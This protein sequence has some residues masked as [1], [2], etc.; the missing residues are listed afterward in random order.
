MT[1]RV[2]APWSAQPVP[3]SSTGGVITVGGT[4]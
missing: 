1:A 2:P 4:S 3:Y